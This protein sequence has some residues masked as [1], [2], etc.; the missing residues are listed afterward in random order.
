MKFAVSGKGGVGK[1]T[2]SAN[3]AFRMKDRGY[4]VFAI[5]ADPDLSL[6]TVLGI[7]E[8][9]INKL[10]PIVEMRQMITDRTQGDGSFYVLNPEVDDILDDFSIDVNGIKFLKM[11]AIKT[12]GSSCYC[13]ENTFLN[14][15]V[16]AIV[17]KRKE[18]VLL[19]MGA[20][21]EHLTRGTSRCV[22]CL[23]IVT[24]PSVV[25]TDTAKVTR[26]LAEEIGIKHIYYVGNKIRRPEEIEFLKS[27]L[28][29]ENI[30]GTI[31]YNDYLLDQAMGIE[32]N[33]DSDDA[34]RFKK[35]IDAIFDS[36]VARHGDA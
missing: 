35:E 29:Q 16:S 34:K 18:A 15:L 5:D 1:T 11:G 28:P 19:D 2:L 7:P 10:Q 14:S 17:I 31:S 3:L 33:E 21:I 23:V 25:S 22:D 26:K 30:L 4:Q 9:E 36:I 13:L 27:R 6:G 24:E 20:G 32:L 8:E 12:G